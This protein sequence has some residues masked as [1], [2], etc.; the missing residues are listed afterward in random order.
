METRYSFFIR[1]GLLMVD[2]FIVNFSYLAGHLVAHHTTA[3]NLPAYYLPSKALIFNL[4][5]LTFAAIMRLYTRSAI[6]KPPLLFRLTGMTFLLQAAFFLIFLALTGERYFAY[7]FLPTCYT[8]LLSLLILRSF[9]ISHM[10]EMIL[11][12][13]Q[14]HTRTA[15][16]G[17]TQTGQK[18]ARYFID[19]QNTYMFEGFFD[20]RKDQYVQR[21]EEEEAMEIEQYIQ[22]AAANNIREIYSTVMPE[23]HRLNRLMEIAD[24]NCVRVK[25][26]PDV[27][28]ALH[29]DYH[30]EYM[31][32]IPVISMRP[33]PLSQHI[34]Y[35]L[36][37]R[38]F[39]ILFS[40]LVILLL[41][42]WMTPLLYLLIKL[43][44]KGPLFFKQKRTGRGNCP[45]VCYKFRSM[46]VNHTCDHL[47]ASRND[48]RVT[49][50]GAFLRKTNL[51]EMPQFFNV[52]MGQMSVVGPRPHMLKHTEEYRS[53]IRKYMVRQFLQPGI[54]GWAQVNGYRG[55]TRDTEMMARRVEYD[56]YYIENWSWKLDIKIILMTIATL[57][58]GDKN[59]Y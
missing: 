10:K 30:I 47:Q 58:K 22:F 55:E 13:V 36:Q 39:D 11:R 33:D 51:D 46:R 15:I 21:N 16:V 41:L 59:A 52:F 2:F 26:I 40:V 45:F 5:W 23:K 20:E 29:A 27:I 44:S 50:L 8:I 34:S 42:S 49:K 38:T 18:L 3:I 35:L 57:F 31:D 24:E 25:F 4:G 6:T 14:M 43:D 19:H 53:L 9:F 54:T 56:I 37:K 7:T 48:P 12:K 1:L 17:H 32:T 28:G